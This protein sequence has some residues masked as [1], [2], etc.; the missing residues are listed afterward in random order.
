MM[1]EIEK[2]TVNIPGLEELILWEMSILLKVIYRINTIPLKIPAS[3]FME[4]E[5]SYHKISMDTE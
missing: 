2:D 5:K 4:V 3:F 1:K